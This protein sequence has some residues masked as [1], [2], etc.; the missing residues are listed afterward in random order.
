M[1]RRSVA[2]AILLGASAYAQPPIAL[3][4]DA[5]DAPRRIFHSTVSIP[6]TP[7]PLTLVYPK[8]IPGEHGPTGPI[9]DVAGITITAGGAGGAGG[10]KKI[11]WRRDLT[12]LWAIK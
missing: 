3:S 9:G 11:P 12:E 8:W 1:I 6:V 2:L 5:R 10:G 7:G 4:V